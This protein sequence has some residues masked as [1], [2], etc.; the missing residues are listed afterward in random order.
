MGDDRRAVLTTDQVRAFVDRAPRCKVRI[1]VHCQPPGL[2][3]FVEAQLV[4]VS[5][6]GMFLSS[7]HLLAIGTSV[8]FQFNLDDD[9]IVLRGSAEVVR[10]TEEGERGMGLQFTTLD[11]AGRQLIDRMVETSGHEPPGAGAGR[12]PVE[13]AHGSLRIVLSEITAAYF[14]Y[15][16]LLHIGIGGCFIPSTEDVP[17][18]TG[19][20]L[21]IVDTDGRVMLRCK[22]K[23]AAKQEHRIGIRLLDVDRVTLLKLRAEIAKLAPAAP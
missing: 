18:G 6:S 11:E 15:N 12:T 20:Q 3:D 9:V 8:D 5:R 21:D 4:D 23:V 13:I 7:Q 16:P 14:T 22:A 19:Y 1:V 17:L 2:P 10:L